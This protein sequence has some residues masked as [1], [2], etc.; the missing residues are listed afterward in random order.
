M[1][2]D[3]IFDTVRFRNMGFA[4]LVVTMIMDL[5]HALFLESPSAQLFDELFISRLNWGLEKAVIYIN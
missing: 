2:Y 1:T 3:V 5:E 4:I